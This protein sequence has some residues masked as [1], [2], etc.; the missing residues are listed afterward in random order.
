[1]PLRQGIPVFLMRSGQLAEFYGS[2]PEDLKSQEE[3]DENPADPLDSLHTHGRERRGN[4]QEGLPQELHGEGEN[5]PGDR[6]LEQRDHTFNLLE[7]S[8]LG[9]EVGGYPDL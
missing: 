4:A 7:V 9:M 1:M 2:S 5:G 3:E 8:S 6:A